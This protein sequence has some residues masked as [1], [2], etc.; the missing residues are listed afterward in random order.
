MVTGDLV[1]LNEEKEF[2]TIG[3][4]KSSVPEETS[5]VSG[6]IATIVQNRHRST[7]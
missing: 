5:A 1:A 3:K 7:L 2:A 4:Q 6:T